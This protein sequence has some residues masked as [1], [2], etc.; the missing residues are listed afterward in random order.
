MRDIDLKESKHA[1]LELGWGFKADEKMG[2]WDEE[3]I[4]HVGMF[5]RLEIDN[6]VKLD[7]YQT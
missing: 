4:G 6:N 5:K 1:N 2:A 7:M 3:G